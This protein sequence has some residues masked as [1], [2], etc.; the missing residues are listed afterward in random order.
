[1]ILIV[2]ILNMNIK[3]VNC[4]MIKKDLYVIKKDAIIDVEMFMKKTNSF[5]FLFN[6]NLFL[7][8]EKKV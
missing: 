8:L 1:M 3:M 7:I 2:E 4:Y 6:Y 5:L